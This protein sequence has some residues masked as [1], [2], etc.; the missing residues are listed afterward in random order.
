MECSISLKLTTFTK[1]TFSQLKRCTITNYDYIVSNIFQMPLEQLTIQNASY[2]RKFEF[3]LTLQYLYLSNFK[4]LSI[5]N[6]SQHHQLK[7]LHIHDME[8][9]KFISF[10]KEL[11]HVELDRIGFGERKT[12]I[13][14][15]GIES[16]S[17]KSCLF[18]DIKKLTT[19]ELPESVS[20]LII[21]DCDDIGIE[22]LFDLSLSKQ[23]LMKLK[24]Y[25]K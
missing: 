1:F 2:L 4:Y 5:L 17:L 9:L 24:K 7:K 20:S 8:H 11:E 23:D 25:S 15:E 3:P 12:N 18:H 10:P 21:I 6:L 19:I 16:S 22:N 14:L 13:T